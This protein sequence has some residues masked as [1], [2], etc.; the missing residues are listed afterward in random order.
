M[1]ALRLRSGQA[2]AGIQCSLSLGNPLLLTGGLSRRRG[3]WL[4][5]WRRRYGCWRC[6][7]SLLLCRSTTVMRKKQE[8]ICRIV[9]AVYHMA[10]ILA[11]EDDTGKGVGL[12]ARPADQ[13]TVDVSLSHEAVDIIGL[14]TATVQQAN[15]L[16]RLLIRQ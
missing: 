11:E 15:R 9:T 8:K 16:G 4:A 10:W 12:Q 2:P 1:P 6:G 13:G 7:L 14:H 5:G 3:R